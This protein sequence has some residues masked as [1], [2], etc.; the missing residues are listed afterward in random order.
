MYWIIYDAAGLIVGGPLSNESDAIRI[1][2]NAGQTVLEVSQKKINRK[3]WRVDLI[4]L[5]LRAWT[6]QEIDDAVNT[7]AADNAAKQGRKDSAR[8]NKG[9]G[10]SVP[11]LVARLDNL[12]EVLQ[13]EG[14]IPF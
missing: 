13:D 3:Q 7:T 1:A 6:Q 12:I 2:S 10:N 14:V 4:T 5:D 9:Q 8:D 11:D